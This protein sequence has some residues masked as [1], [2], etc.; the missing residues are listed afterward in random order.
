MFEF[1]VTK[2]MKKW[3][4]KGGGTVVVEKVATHLCLIL[5]VKELKINVEQS[6]VV[7]TLNIVKHYISCLV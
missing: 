2:D 6:R 3:Y 1:K 4:N 5:V 7:I